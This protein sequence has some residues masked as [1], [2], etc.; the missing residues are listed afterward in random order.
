[1]KE[2]NFFIQRTIGFEFNL[3][4]WENFKKHAEK[5]DKSKNVV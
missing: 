1:M 3:E 4:W 5:V 2:N